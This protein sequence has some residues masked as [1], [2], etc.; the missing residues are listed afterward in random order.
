M[1]RNP[2]KR[3]CQTPGCNAWAMRY[4][5]GSG[6]AVPANPPGLEPV[7]SRPTPREAAGLAGRDVVEPKPAWRFIGAAKNGLSTGWMGKRL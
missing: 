1:P 7:G 6:K 2:N 4:L 3:R 5:P